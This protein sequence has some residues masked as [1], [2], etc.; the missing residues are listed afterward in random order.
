MTNFLT[1]YFYNFNV[2]RGAK[3]MKNAPSGFQNVKES[4][5]VIDHCQRPV[6]DT[7][8][9]REVISGNITVIA[10]TLEDMEFINGYKKGL[11]RDLRQVLCRITDHYRWIKSA[12]DLAILVENIDDL[13]RAKKEGKV[14]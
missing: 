5:I 4:A 6:L 13:Y 7:E 10:V 11:E 12:S 2:I 1:L 3:K 14:E 8:Y 9:F